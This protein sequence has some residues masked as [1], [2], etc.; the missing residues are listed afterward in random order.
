M[1]H[2]ILTILKILGVFLLWFFA[3]IFLLLLLVLFV[4]VKYRIKAIKGEEVE[5]RLLISW[6]FYIFCFRLEYGSQR[7][8]IEFLLC[9]I[10]LKI[11]GKKKRR[12]KEKKEKEKIYYEENSLPSIKKEEEEL[13]REEISHLQ[14]GET[15]S[16]KREHKKRKKKSIFSFI[17]KIFQFFKKIGYTFSTLCDRIK[18]IK[19][20]WEYYTGLFSDEKNIQIIKKCLGQ[21]KK[22]VGH[23]MPRKC[24][25]FLRIGMKDPA[26]TGRIL[27]ILGILYPLY[28]EKIKIIPEFEQTIFEGEILLAGRIRAFVLLR[29]GL[30]LYFNRE[31]KQLMK[32]LKK[33]EA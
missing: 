17:Q 33:E 9:G 28:G 13:K 10:P 2:I 15:D 23:I 31:L 20:E 4:P 14:D 26:W 1:L 12:K 18:S 16:K 7:K 25:G 22:G 32:A 29:M 11:S 21:V 5:G 19:D 8:N 6:L 30:A 24:K 27:S 3:F